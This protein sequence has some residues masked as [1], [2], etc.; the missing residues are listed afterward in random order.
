[1]IRLYFVEMPLVAV[2]GQEKWSRWG[3]G[4][5]QDEVTRTKEI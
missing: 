2:E 4:T 5:A 3:P 1:M